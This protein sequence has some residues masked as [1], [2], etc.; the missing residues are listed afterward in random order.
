MKARSSLL[1]VG[2]DSYPA[3]LFACSTPWR[4]EELSLGA[5]IDKLAANIALAR[6]A[7]GVH[8]RSDSIRG[9]KLGE[10]VAIGLLADTS[11][12][13][14]EKFD[15]F[16]LSR[17]DGSRIRISDGAVQ[18]LYAPSQV[19]SQSR[20]NAVVPGVRVSDPT[21][22]VDRPHLGEEGGTPFYGRVIRF[23]FYARTA[24]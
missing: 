3:G 1:T 6:D 14:N 12:T 21:H 18:S 17:F 23:D 2:A 4:G 20:S 11:R 19:R 24:K 16:V 8:F 10:E 22:T 9:L 5:E 13:Y 7:A 15:R